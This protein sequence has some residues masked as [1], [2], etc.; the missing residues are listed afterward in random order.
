LAI[1]NQ[2]AL[3]TRVAAAVDPGWKQRPH[4]HHKADSE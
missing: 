3:R 1:V 4:N 2:Y